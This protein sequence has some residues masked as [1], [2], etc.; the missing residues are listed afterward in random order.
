MIQP[1]ATSAGIPWTSPQRSSAPQ[2]FTL[3]S[4]SCSSPQWMISVL[5]LISF[6]RT[7]WGQ[8]RHTEVTEA[9]HT[10]KN[11][12]PMHRVKETNPKLKVELIGKTNLMHSL[13]PKHWQFLSP[14]LAEFPQQFAFAPV[15]SIASY[16]S[17]EWITSTFHWF[18]ISDW[19]L[20]H[21]IWNW[22]VNI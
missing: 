21:R 4:W 3:S 7:K 18:P 1:P 13:K 11:I 6:M 15:S 2:P 20:C 16:V 14:W 5:H 12:L 22:F 9:L 19:D 10:I 17:V 8:Y